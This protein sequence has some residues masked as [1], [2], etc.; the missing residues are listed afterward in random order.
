MQLSSQPADERKLYSSYP[1]PIQ[2]Y[3]QQQQQ[4]YQSPMASPPVDPQKQEYYPQQQ[5][6]PVQHQQTMPVQQVSGYQT[7]VPLINLQEAAAPVDCPSCRSR[8][9]TRTE[10]HSGNT[11]KYADEE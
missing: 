1:Q 7:A 9:L 8:A 4:P 11:T 5:Q 3:P 10:F 6:Q 2:H